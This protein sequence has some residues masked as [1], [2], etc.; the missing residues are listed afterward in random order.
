[1]KRILIVLVTALQLLATVKAAEAPTIPAPNL[2]QLNT[3]L[4]A[5]RSAIT[6]I[7]NAEKQALADIDARAT[8]DKENRSKFFQTKKEEFKAKEKLIL[9]DIAKLETK[10]H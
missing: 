3:R 7:E 1:M 8:Q 10:A 9:E 2:N 4:T 6:N 5:T